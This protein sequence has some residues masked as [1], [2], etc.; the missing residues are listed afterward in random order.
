MIGARLIQYRR[1]LS[2]KC[3]PRDAEKPDW[4]RLLETSLK[5]ATPLN[6]ITYAHRTCRR[7]FPS[8]RLLG[9]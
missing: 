3:R 1:G 8:P 5:I 7:S 6:I 2:R 9:T 4:I